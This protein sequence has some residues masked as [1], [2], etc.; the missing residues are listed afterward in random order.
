MKTLYL[1]IG[2]GKTGSSY[3]QSV[4]AK[5]ADAL[6]TMGYAYPLD[7]HS[8]RAESGKISSGN[9]HMLLAELDNPRG[10]PALVNAIAEDHPAVIL[11]SEI[12]SSHLAVSMNGREPQVF[13]QAVVDW[14]RSKGFEQIE[15]LLLIRNPI[16]AFCSNYQQS[17]KRHGNTASAVS[18]AA[19]YNTPKLMLGCLEGLRSHPQISVTIKNYS[20]VKSCLADVLAEWLGVDSGVLQI[21]EVK[22][23]NRSLTLGELELQRQVNVLAGMSGGYL[24]DP[25]CEQLPDVQSEQVALPI[26]AQRR[27]WENNL[28]AMSAINALLPDEHHYRFDELKNDGDPELFVFTADQLRVIGSEIGQLILSAEAATVSDVDSQLEELQRR[29]EKLQKRIEEREINFQATKEKL[30]VERNKKE[31]AREQL[32][33]MEK[34]GNGPISRLIKPLVKLEQS[35]IKRFLRRKE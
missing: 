7:V 30:R 19:I 1:H 3:L 28:E 2:H 34:L 26:D 15:V 17:V 14:A 25:L 16:S 4:L 6:R 13:L 32:R 22:I 24:S 33:S 29:N 5:S 35:V 9:G 8:Q 23:V 11:S 27:I 12:L 20:V 18:S 10:A 21:P 31:Q